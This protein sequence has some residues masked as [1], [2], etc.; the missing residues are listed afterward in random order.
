MH[1][2]RSLIKELKLLQVF[3]LIFGAFLSIGLLD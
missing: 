2:R 1:A 3:V